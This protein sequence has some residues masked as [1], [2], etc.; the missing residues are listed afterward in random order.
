MSS[1]FKLVLLLVPSVSL[2]FFK[3][4]QNRISN[5]GCNSFIH[6]GVMNVRLLVCLIFAIVSFWYFENAVGIMLGWCDNP[7]L[8]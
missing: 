6:H 3:H 2:C 8:E 4:M 5:D 1:I 7:T